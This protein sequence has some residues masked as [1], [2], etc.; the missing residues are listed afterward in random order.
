MNL[1]LPTPLTSTPNTSSPERVL[2]SHVR[3]RVTTGEISGAIIGTWG[4]HAIRLRE[5]DVLDIDVM[6][7]FPQVTYELREASDA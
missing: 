5:G 7:G 6:A 1:L 4:A 3:L 2:T